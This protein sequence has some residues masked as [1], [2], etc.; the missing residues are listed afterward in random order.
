MKSRVC[1][2]ETVVMKRACD[3]LF[4]F[5]FHGTYAVNI[6]EQVKKTLVL[7]LNVFYCFGDFFFVCSVVFFLPCV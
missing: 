3:R 2:L 4:C 7:N 6:K 1:E 5:S